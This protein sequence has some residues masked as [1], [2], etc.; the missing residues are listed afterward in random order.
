MP[1]PV[2]AK[3]AADQFNGKR[4]L[5]TTRMFLFDLS[6]R[7][8]A[9]RAPALADEFREALHNAKDRDSVLVAS[10]SMITEVERVLSDAPLAPDTGVPR[11]AP[12]SPV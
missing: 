4:S 2:T 10:R 3:V 1:E 8:F 5:A 6:E 11:S 12:E 7:M 9:R